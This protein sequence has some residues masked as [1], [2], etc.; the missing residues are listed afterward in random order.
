MITLY[1]ETILDKATLRV[2]SALVRNDEPL[3]A[4]TV[5]EVLHKWISGEVEGLLEDAT[6]YLQDAS[7]AG[8][9]LARLLAQAHQDRPPTL[10]LRITPRELEFLADL[11]V[12]TVAT[13]AAALGHNQET[14]PL[15]ALDAKVSGLWEAYCEDLDDEL[16][17]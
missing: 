2:S 1:E 12:N 6:E 7:P 3:P 4:A 17:F 5:R 8:R 13:V 16:L 15:P 14:G 9:S 11:L 10:S